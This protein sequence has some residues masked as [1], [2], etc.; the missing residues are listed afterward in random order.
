MLLNPYF[1]RTVYAPAMGLGFLATYVKKK[2]DCDIKVYD[3]IVKKLNRTTLLEEIKTCDFLGMICFTESR[4]QCFKFAQDAKRINPNIKIIIGGPHVIGLDILILVKYYFID[5]IVRNEGEESFLE[6]IQNKP[7]K[8]ILGITWRNSNGETVQNKDR[9]LT[10]NISLYEYDYELINDIFQWKDGEVNMKLRNVNHLPIIASRGCPYR[11][12][13]CASF[14]QWRCNYRSIPPKELVDLM[15]SLVNKYNIHYFRFYDALFM[16]S[17]YRLI[18]FSKEI[19]KR[20]LNISFRIDLRVNTRLEALTHLRKAGCE[21]VGF[22]L[23]SGSN[24]I[25]KR[26]NKGVTYLDT[27]TILKNCKKLGFWTIGF[28]MISLPDETQSDMNATF[29][30]FKYLQVYN[31]Q[32]FKIHPGTPFYTELKNKQLIEDTVWFD[33]SM[34]DE[35]FH[36]KELFITAIYSRKEINTIIINS[37]YRF[38]INYPFLIYSR[39]GYFKGSFYILGS[40]VDTLLNGF[41]H[42]TI[43]SK[44]IRN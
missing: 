39:H 6:I 31:L 34:P 9:P 44:L 26:I 10:E 30:L 12:S 40:I 17:D 11:C 38:C 29:K 32:F 27:I 22:G 2:V 42:R 16:G 7:A 24:K 33:N 23:E 19:L 37:F 28:F 15:E 13:F 8:N 14:N 41:L 36:S 25:L 21:I 43:Y 4:F 1:D 35:L 3:P 18:E 5:F 20:N